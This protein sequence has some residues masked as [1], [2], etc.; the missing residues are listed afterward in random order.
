[1]IIFL[2]C[3]SLFQVTSVNAAFAYSWSV[4]GES[5]TLGSTNKAGNVTW[6]EDKILTLNNYNGGQLKIECYGT[7]LGYTFPI[8]LV[9]DNSITVTDNVGIIANAPITFIGDG[10]LTIN[11]PIPIGSGSISNAD[12][13]LTN[14]EDVEFNESTTVMIYPN[15]SITSE[16]NLKQDKVTSSSENKETVKDK[17]TDNNKK[18]KDKKIFTNNDLINIIILLYCSISF[19]TIIILII[20]LAKNKNR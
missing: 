19:I 12:Y 4:D 14:I 11:A 1:M 8:K 10:K 6:G 7:G 16:D 20:K 17:V 18:V 5:L 9:G 2:S 13:T 15:N 3:I